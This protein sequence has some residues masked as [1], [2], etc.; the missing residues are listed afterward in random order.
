MVNLPFTNGMENKITKHPILDSGWM[1]FGMV[2]IMC[3]VNSLF[4]TEIRMIQIN[5]E[6]WMACGR[7]LFIHLRLNYLDSWKEYE[8]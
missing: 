3:S 5:P 8:A 6:G 2:A 4:G 1:T 7:L